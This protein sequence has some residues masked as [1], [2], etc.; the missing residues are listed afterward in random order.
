M[1]W[2][3]KDSISKRFGTCCQAHSSPPPRPG[4]A[5]TFGDHQPIPH[6][7]YFFTLCQR[8]CTQYK[9]P[10]NLHGLLTASSKTSFALDFTTAGPHKCS[11]GHLIHAREP[12]VLSGLEA[13]TQ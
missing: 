12:V 4:L 9:C 2:D 11:L 6:D 7:S 8:C 10:L 1:S 5:V 13:K 3:N